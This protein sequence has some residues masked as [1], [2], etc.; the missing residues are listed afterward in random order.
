[1]AGDP[2]RSGGRYCGN[3]ALYIN[4]GREHCA[5]EGAYLIFEYTPPQT[6]MEIAFGGHRCVNASGPIQLQDDERF[7]DFLESSG[8]PPRT[9]VYINSGG[10]HVQAAMNMGRI[11]RERWMATHVGQ[12]LLDHTNG[13][14][15][16]PVVPRRFVD[17][18]C[19]SAATLFY[20][21]G[22]LRYLS[23]GSEFG[24][25]QFSFRDPEPSLLGLSQILSSKIA[26]YISDMGIPPEFLEISAS[27]T[28]DGIRLVDH[29][30]LRN[31]AVVTDGETPVQWTVQSRNNALYVRGERDSLY[32]HHKICLGFIKP[33][34]YLH[35]VIEAQG[36]EEHLT[37]FP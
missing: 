34:F 2:V 15:D 17:G 29:V 20:L 32:G 12:Y 28:S 6:P 27:T 9:D 22:R 11:L 18:R 1:M 21:G 25:H 7:L 26:R 3:N 4:N 37:Q 31:L 8:V 23:G 14:P 10:G 19:M 30:E 36:R 5:I 33:S 35:A 16:S 13:G 24:V